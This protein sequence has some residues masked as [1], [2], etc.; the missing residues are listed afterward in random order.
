M[1]HSPESEEP[2]EALLAAVAGEDR[3]AYRRLYERTS[4]KLF[5]VVLRI[6]KDRGM[7]EEVLQEVYLGIWRGASSYAAEKARPMTWMITIA[8]NRAIDA[9]RGRREV[10]L[11][12]GEDGEDRI[13][14]I[15]DPFDA[16]ATFA[17]RD[18]LTRCLDLLEEAHRHCILLA[19]CEG[20]SR[21]ELAAR[22]GKNVNTI[23]TWLHRGLATLRGCLSS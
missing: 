19:Y 8:R 4:A 11:D 23:K 21:E 12:P 1:R 6:V 2:L 20:W 15:P 3:A 7:A 9:V 18:A 22:T 16:A 17:D 5:G 10:L 14:A 13:A